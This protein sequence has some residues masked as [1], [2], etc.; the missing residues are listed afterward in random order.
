MSGQSSEGS[1]RPGARTPPPRGGAAAKKAASKPKRPTGRVKIRPWW[2]RPSVLALPVIL[3]IGAVIAIVVSSGG[4]SGSNRAAVNFKASN[5][6]VYGGIGPEGVPLEAGPVLAP[7]N[8]SLTSAPIDGVQCGATEA[9]TVHYHVHLIVFVDGQPRSVPLAVGLVPPAVVQQTS[10][11]PF[12][13]GSNTCLFWIHTHA[14]D[15]I[16]HIEAPADREFVL[17]QFFDIWGQPLSAG[18]VGPDK[19]PVTA[20][21]D[22]KAYTGD[23][24]NI[25]MTSHEQIVLNVGGPAVTP[26]PISFSG[27]QL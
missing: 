22:G 23:P 26:P 5:V 19:G 1:S 27:T 20:T 12:A 13:G 2:L 4:G 14:Q 16:I 11:G 21:V 7:A 25:V 10:S 3:L 9:T 6:A 18:Q 17:R 8:P 24:G 15:G